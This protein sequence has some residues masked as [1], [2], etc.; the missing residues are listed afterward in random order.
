MPPQDPEQARWFAREIL[1]HEAALRAYLRS[2]FATL[3]DP[4]DVIQ[5]TFIRVLRAHERGP[6]ESPRGLLFATA[7]NAA[8]DL[9]RR[10]AV[11]QTF[12]ITE[13][14]A[15]HVFDNAPD[16]PEAVSRRQEAD[17]LAQAIA[18][19][20]PRCREILV[21]RKFEN[22]SHREIAQRLG[23]AEHTVEAQLTKA[24]HR[25]ADFFARQGLPRS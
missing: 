10:R 22:L 20:P 9:L 8:L 16:V 23:I 14:D 5:D 11:V 15:L 3:S 4:E 21:L 7:R 2:Q 1:P 13:A 25:C 19:L 12:P 24:L 18:E 6:I 17:L